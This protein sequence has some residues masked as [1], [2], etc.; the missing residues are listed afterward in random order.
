MEKSERSYL[1]GSVLLS[2]NKD[3]SSPEEF[4]IRSVIGEGGSA[5]CYEAERIR[6]NGTV[7]TGKLKEFY[8]AETDGCFPLERKSDG[9]LV[10]RAA[11][12]QAFGGNA[13]RVSRRV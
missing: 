4:V 12:A 7:E 5:V 8:P 10:P 6:Q 1:R 13:R 11:S 9:R 3:G 2:G